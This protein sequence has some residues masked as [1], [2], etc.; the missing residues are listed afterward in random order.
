MVT[1]G[2]GVVAGV[3]GM[4]VATHLLQPLEG[5]AIFIG[6]LVSVIVA[7]IVRSSTKQGAD[8]SGR[9]RGSRG[10]AAARDVPI[11]PLRLRLRGA[12]ER[13]SHARAE[14]MIEGFP[15]LP[16]FTFERRRHL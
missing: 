7:S 9:Y 5:H 15:R 16:C 10:R 2:V 4:G 14:A 11:A 12:A 6:P 3:V 8:G 13:W 1:V